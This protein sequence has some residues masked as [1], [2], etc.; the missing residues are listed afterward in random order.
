VTR[1][2]TRSVI[3]RDS[4]RAGGSKILECDLAEAKAAGRVAGESRE[5]ALARAAL[6][7]A[8]AEC[9]RLRD[10]GLTLLHHLSRAQRAG[11]RLDTGARP[12]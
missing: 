7:A 10:T 9:A 11:P 12:A 1:P 3:R 5:L 6:E 8:D 4:T 2:V